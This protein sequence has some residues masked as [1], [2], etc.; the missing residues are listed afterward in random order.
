LH[1]VMYGEIGPD[2]GAPLSQNLMTI[3][4]RLL[5]VIKETKPDCMAVED[6]FYGKNVKSLIK[7]S[8]VRG[9]VLLT[10]AHS[11][12]PIFEYAPLEIKKAVVG[13]GRAEKR[14]VQQMVK[15]ILQ[16]ADLPPSDA[17]DAMA[18]AI[19]HANALKIPCL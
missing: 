3:Y 18:V 12:T 17:A 1:Y 4:N 6:V 9:V 7:Q 10:G 11:G 5:N 14:Q 8:H 16:L 15:A 2:K 13:Y 19:C